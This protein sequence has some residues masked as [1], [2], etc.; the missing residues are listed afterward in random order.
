MSCLFYIVWFNFG[1]LFC[2]IV[3]C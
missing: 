3:A 1:V 2:G